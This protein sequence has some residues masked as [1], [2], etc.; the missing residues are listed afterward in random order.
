MNKSN[1]NYN[2]IIILKIQ[3]LLNNYKNNS[4]KNTNSNIDKKI[5]PNKSEN[6]IIKKINF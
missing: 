1:S 3:T 4:N 6:N 2:R 5:N